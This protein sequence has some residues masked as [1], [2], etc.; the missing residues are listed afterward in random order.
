MSEFKDEMRK[1][2]VIMEIEELL[3]RVET[4]IQD[5]DSALD[6]PSW[7]CWSVIVDALA[8]FEDLTERE[9]TCVHLPRSVEI[10]VDAYVVKHIKESY[11]GLRK[12]KV[13]LGLDVV[14]D[15]PHFKFE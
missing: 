15:A 13:L 7:V 10:L 5:V 2:C 8:M 14:L 6:A 9:A 3:E 4:R 12:E 11:M 1:K